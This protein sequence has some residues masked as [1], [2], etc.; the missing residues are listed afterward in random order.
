MN[1][2]T[3]TGKTDI[4]KVLVAVAVTAL[5]AAV[6]DIMYFS[7][8]EWRFRTNRLNKILIDKEKRASDYLRKIENTLAKGPDNGSPAQAA[9]L[10][11]DPGDGLVYLIYKNGD[12]TSWSDN[13]AAFPLKYD[14]AF[15]KHDALF[16]S[17]AWFIPVH[18]SYLDYDLVALIV[19]YRQYPIKNDLLTEGFAN[20]FKVPSS[21][22]ISFDEQNSRFIVT[23]VE[24][25]FHFGLVF[26]E[27]K[28]NTAFIILPVLMWFILFM[29]WVWLARK[30]ADLMT[31]KQNR[32]IGLATGIL[33]LSVVYLS[34]LIFGLPGSVNST[35][36][37]SPFI[38]S[39]GWL[40]PSPGH[41]LL[42]S[43]LM[44]SALYI[45]ITGLP[46]LMPGNGTPGKRL[47]HP[48]ALAALAYASFV[49][50]E[51]AFRT[52]ITRS[53]LNFEAYRILDLTLMS[54]V[55]F[56][57]VIILLTIPVVLLMRVFSI[58]R[59]LPGSD[60]LAVVVAG[61]LI[62]PAL[63]LAGAECSLY[64]VAFI[65]LVTL[66]VYLRTDLT[67]SLFSSVVVYAV[68]TGIYTTAIV[69]KQS[70]IRDNENLKVLAVSL[71]SDN[72]MIAE[73]MLID[74]WPALNNDT[75]LQDLMDR[76]Y[77]TPAD[78]NSVYRYLQTR[79][80]NGYWS[81]YD[82]NIILCRDDSQLE[83]PAQDSY[84]SNCF[85]F[86]DERIRRE[87]DSITG[88]GFWFMRNQ[89][90]RAY[91]LSRLFYEYSPFLTNGL[92]IELVSH[93]ETYQAGY[94]ELLIDNKSRRY[95][96][97]K[98]ISYAK[99]AGEKLVL[100]SGSYPYDNL[101]L[102]VQ[103]EEGEYRI[104]K[105]NGYRHLV[106]NHGGMTL[107]IS[108]EVTSELN[109]VVTFAYFF[110]VI[111]IISLILLLVFIRQNPGIF[112]FGTFRRKLQ[113]AFGGVL[114]VVF[115]ITIIASIMLTV[116]QFKENHTKNLRE[117]IASVSIELEHKLS[118]E[119]NLSSGW[120]TPDYYSLNELLLKFSNVFMT[121]INLYS[122]EGTLIATSRP[123]VFTGRL[124]GNLID[125][126]AYYA[127]KIETSPE[128]IGE[129]SIGH[130]K[131][132]S[133]YVPFLND[134]NKILAYI[135]L[136]YFSMQNILTGE[137]SNMVVTIVNFTF[138]LLMLMMWLSVF[139]GERLTSP[140]TLLQSAMASV[141]Y[142]KKNEYI[143]YN[144]RDEV[145]ELV[146][147]YNR[148]I[149]ELDESAVKLARSERELA[150]REMARQI[151]HEI[152]NPLTP[153]KLNV[154]QLF[155]WWNDKVPDFSKKLEKFTDNQ[156]EYIDNLSSIASAFSYF[157]R[158]PGAEPAEVDVLA[159]LQTTVEMFG[160]TEDATVS[161][162]AGTISKAVI[163]ADKEHLN[164]IFSNLIKNALQAIPAGVH[165]II[166]ISLTATFDKLLVTIKDNG[167]GIPEE[168]KP[169]MFTPNFTTK[170]SGMG[171]GL[172][173]VKR[174]VE[175]AGGNIWFESEKDKGTSFFIELPLLYTVERL[176]KHDVDK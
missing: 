22:R 18:T 132:L 69:T 60:R 99:Y 117:K 103:P 160:H 34:V 152:K 71:A 14:S 108:R 63:S 17:N 139:L 28:P 142:G 75:L 87:G 33:L 53:T 119:T 159:Q 130:L 40:L 120:H 150:W 156:I 73:S 57:S 50:A 80:F 4:R 82:L 171:L 161:L 81:G 168:I 26:P 54:L 122:P 68:L 83:I 31:T 149:D 70:E 113:L 67:L 45:F 38:I 162:D 153:M 137:I 144:S 2:I 107:V 65:A 127:L 145:G 37:F 158:L 19:L 166:T 74:I 21:T 125:P 64:G 131:Y 123:E 134:E 151:A 112:E 42:I 136:P 10:T 116:G 11:P 167:A 47:I 111:L 176:S 62:I 35:E 55:G 174:Y 170:S 48:A 141:E 44:V 58:M 102:P 94:P 23:G 126:E 27:I 1:S 41:L 84:A 124:E 165:G 148:M 154:Q 100:R 105:G 32:G 109:I 147:Q 129:E 8:M 101:L 118:A 143:H 140:M 46:P 95:P 163:M 106:Y 88:T 135:N 13:S 97:L 77:F 128:Y 49:L 5:L 169:R 121:D 93:I 66:L 30:A 115:L 39:A 91:Y 9:S 155:K 7:D 92:F 6:S 104:T 56:V 90:G 25:D 76:E 3:V 164:G 96:G 98:N 61:F 86:F 29:L 172:S 133:A 52:I 146:R 24:G 16:I 173:I 36:L 85:V 89:G 78:I 72:D 157:A 20:D 51:A 175:T 15:G 110:I 79:Y 43:V 12:L 59:P 138:L 114:T